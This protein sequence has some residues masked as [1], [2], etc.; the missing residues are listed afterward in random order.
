VTGGY[1]Y[2]GSRW[3]ALFGTYLYGDYCSGRIW[4]DRSELLHTNALVVSFG[5]DDAGELYLVD[6]RGSLLR[7]DGGIDRRRAA[8]H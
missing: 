3:P 8:V 4:G 2:R 7:I 6:Q 1:R 5:E